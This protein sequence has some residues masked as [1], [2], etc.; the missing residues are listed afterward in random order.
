VEAIMSKI[1]NG[2]KYFYRG[3]EKTEAGAKKKC[4]RLI[5]SGYMAT[6]TKSLAKSKP[7]FLVWSR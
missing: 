1:F 2:K 6:W 3:I 5:N 4:Q 7:G